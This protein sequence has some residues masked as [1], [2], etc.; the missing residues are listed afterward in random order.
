LRGFAA[1]GDLPGGVSKK[2]DADFAIGFS[3]KGDIYVEIS[4]YA[5]PGYE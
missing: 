3:R 1:R 5:K 4:N 2:P